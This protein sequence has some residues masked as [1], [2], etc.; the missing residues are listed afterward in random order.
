MSTA[1]RTVRPRAADEPRPRQ[2]GVAI[3]RKQIR[4]LAVLAA[5]PF[6]IDAVVH[7]ANASS[8][9]PANGGLITEGNLFRAEAGVA[10]LVALLLVVRPSRSVWMLAC[11]TA[12]TALGAVVLYRYV[13]VGAIGPI[14]NMYEP[15][16]QVPGKLL[17]AYAEASAALLSCVAAI[18]TRPRA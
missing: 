7:G 12:V 18:A 14:P 9:D 16:W 13:N 4:L 3:V 15:T 11:A 2:R 8:Y 17:S 5:V 1:T 6:L 10:A